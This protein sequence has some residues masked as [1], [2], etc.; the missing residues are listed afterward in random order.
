MT[1]P[2]PC[3]QTKRLC[4]KPNRLHRVRPKQTYAG[5]ATGCTR[6]SRHSKWIPRARTATASTP[7]RMVGHGAAG[8]TTG[9]SATASGGCNDPRRGR[10]GAAHTVSHLATQQHDRRHHYSVAPTPTRPQPPPHRDC[11]RTAHRP[12]RLVAHLGA[13]LGRYRLCQTGRWADVAAVGTARCI[14]G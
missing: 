11:R 5:F 4:H 6:R 14:V 1:R 13:T 7:A 10:P 9:A 12:A 8:A 3:C 2:N